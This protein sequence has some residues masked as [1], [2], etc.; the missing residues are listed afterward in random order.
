M[1]SNCERRRD[2]WQRG[3]CDGVVVDDSV[4]NITVGRR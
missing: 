4:E 3:N 1:L 2:L